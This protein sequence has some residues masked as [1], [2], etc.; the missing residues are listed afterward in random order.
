MKHR[1][2][3]LLA[4]LAA[5]GCIRAP[6]I[7]M[8]D[9]ATALE[10]QAS[11][12]FKDVEQRLARAGMSPTPVPLTPNQLEDLGIQP[13]PLVENLGKTPADRVDDLLRR[14]CVGE[15]RDGLLVVTRRQCQA[16]RMSSDDVALVERV[17]R[18][19]MQLWQ[20]MRT[21]R[22]GVPEATLRQGWQQAHAEGVVCGGW[23]EA[24]DGT[25]GEKKC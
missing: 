25:W 16:G 9:R 13:T 5:P 17:N 22:P 3:L 19:R 20:W 2:L 11:G 12:S 10:E 8:V 24:G 7:V 14:H 23:V 1:G 21:V 4:T 18:G 15:G 6:E